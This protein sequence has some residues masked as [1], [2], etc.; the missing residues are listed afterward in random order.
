MA[1]QRAWPVA[2]APGWPSGAGDVGL[3]LI[4]N[5]IFFWMLIICSVQLIFLTPSLHAFTTWNRKV[6]TSGTRS[7]GLWLR[8]LGTQAAAE[9]PSGQSQWGLSSSGESQGPVLGGM[10]TPGRTESNADPSHHLRERFQQD[11]CLICQPGNAQGLGFGLC[12][13]LQ[14]SLPSFLGGHLGTPKGQMKADFSAT[15]FQGHDIRS[16]SRV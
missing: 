12:H 10:R 6:D 13:V 3:T 14:G 1:V 4:L 9:T 5:S 16:G 11:V 15:L 7:G 8:P 2:C